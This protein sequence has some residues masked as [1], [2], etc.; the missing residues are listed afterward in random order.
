M[1]FVAAP[2]A[3][4]PSPTVTHAR[5]LDLV[6]VLARHLNLPVSHDR[7]IYLAFVA[8]VSIDNVAANA[9]CRQIRKMYFSS[10]MLVLNIHLWRGNDASAVQRVWLRG[11]DAWD[12]CNCVLSGH[13]D[14][15]Y[16]HCHR[17]GGSGGSVFSGSRAACIAFIV[18]VETLW[19]RGCFAWTKGIW[20]AHIDLFAGAGVTYADVVQHIFPTPQRM[21]A[22]ESLQ[23]TVTVGD[24]AKIAA[25]RARLRAM[26]ESDNPFDVFIATRRCATWL[27]AV[28]PLAPCLLRAHTHHPPHRLCP[29]PPIQDNVAPE[30]GGEDLPVP[31]HALAELSRKVHAYQSAYGQPPPVAQVREWIVAAWA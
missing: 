31:A 9:V 22:H 16:V 11:R 7:C 12:V 28:R 1:A 2:L 13:G 21:A 6:Y 15:W 3:L 18:E 26:L 10:G 24:E 20:A 19:R 29:I 4:T 30:D 23:P 8:M 25:Q 17:V 14:A 27:Y 5:T